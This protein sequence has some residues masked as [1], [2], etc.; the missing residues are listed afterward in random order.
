MVDELAHDYANQPVVFVE[1]DVD[2]TSLF[3][4]RQGRWWA[5]HGSD[6]VLLPLTMVDSG[7]QIDNGLPY[8]STYENM[9]NSAM[10]RPAQADIH[11]ASSRVGERVHFDV[12]VKNL[13]GVTL[14]SSNGATVWAIVYEEAHVATT[15]RYARAAVS[16][17]ISNL[18]HG[19]VAHVALETPELIGVNWDKLHLLILAEYRPGGTSGPWDMLQATLVQ[20]DFNVEPDSVVFLV[21]PI[22]SKRSIDRLNHRCVYGDQLDHGIG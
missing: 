21:D 10:A 2:N 1:Y 17:G 8:R 19:H 4:A 14:S 6:T 5:A 3:G 11:A 15:D 20:S 22:D 16:A 18:P 9:L 13:S 12:Y 7:N